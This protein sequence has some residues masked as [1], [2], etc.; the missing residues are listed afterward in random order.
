MKEVETVQVECVKAFNDRTLPPEKM[1]RAV[2]SKFKIPKQRAADLE[3]Q[4]YVI[5]KTKEEKEK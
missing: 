4:G 1:Y 3:K 2:G 5:I